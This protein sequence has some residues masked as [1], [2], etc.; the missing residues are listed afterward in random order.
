MTLGI[1]LVEAPRQTPMERC[2]SVPAR[3]PCT[4]VLALLELTSRLR[5]PSRRGVRNR[6]GRRVGFGRPVGNSFRFFAFL[7]PNRPLRATE[8]PRVVGSIRPWPRCIPVT[9]VTPHSG[10]MVNTPVSR[11][12]LTRQLIVATF[13]RCASRVTR[14]NGSA[15][16]QSG[17]STCAGR[18][19]SSRVFI[20]L[21]PMTA[22]TTVS[23]DL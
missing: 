23:L 10:H 18:R 6:L 8:N 13:N 20:S 1:V 4:G 2:S 21:A 15:R 12:R 19:R 16:W 5:R 14:R 3:S 11:G 17:V 7:A 9:W 22:S